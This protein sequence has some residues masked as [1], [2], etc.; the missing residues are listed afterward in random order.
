MALS[1]TEFER[2]A[3]EQIDAVARVARSLTRSDADSDDLTQETY[4]KAVKARDR[5]ELRP[6]GMRPWLLRILHNSWFNRLDRK[7]REPA[8][9][10]PEAL[11]QVPQSNDTAST[12]VHD[13][14]WQD[15]DQRLVRAI[16]QLP[17]TLRTPI[18]LWAIEDLTYS[19]IAEVMNVPVGT[20]MSRLHRARKALAERLDDLARE[21]GLVRE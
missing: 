14:R 2:L 6:G 12:G 15:A 19:Q 21:K 8:L 11:T 10:E 20:V 1:A 7:S 9:L 17:E 3:I 4:L 13:I 16:E 18:L 5:F